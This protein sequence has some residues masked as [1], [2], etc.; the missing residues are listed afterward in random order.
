MNTKRKPSAAPPETAHDN[1]WLAGLGALAQAQAR[2]SEAFDALVREGMAQQAK[3]RETAQ[4]ELSKAAERLATL[5]AG[6]SVTPW[7]RLG[8]IFETRVAQA[9]ERMG[10]PAPQAIGTL[11][12][13][14]DALE[15]R[16]T[17]L[18]RQLPAAPVKPTRTRGKTRAP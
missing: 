3:A 17:A 10:M 5:T 11:L 13:R 7:D 8:G 1:V 18:E 16:I 12:T 6:A 4:A 2:G 14:I 15:Q 9:L